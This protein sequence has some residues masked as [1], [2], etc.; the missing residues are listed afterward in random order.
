MESDERRKL[1]LCADEIL[2]LRRALTRIDEELREVWYTLLELAKEK[3][4]K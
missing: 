3:E 2:I 4:V 1:E